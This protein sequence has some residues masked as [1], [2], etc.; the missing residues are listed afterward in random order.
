MAKEAFDRWNT[1]EYRGIFHRSP[2]VLFATNHNARQYVD[3]CTQCLD[4]QSLPWKRLK[5][6]EETRQVFPT[7]TG[8]CFS[9]DSSEYYSYANLSAGWADARRAI[10]ALGLQC[11]QRGVSFSCGPQ[12]A[13]SSL[14]TTDGGKKITAVETTGGKVVHGDL[15][16]LAT[17]AW[18]SGI[19][20][21]Y[22]SVIST[23]QVLGFVKLTDQEVDK[24]KDLPICINLSSG[25][26][27]FPP[28]PE[29]KY[30]KIAVH[31]WGYTN[32]DDRAKKS[33]QLS[34]GAVIP[35]A[36]D[37]DEAVQASKYSQPPRRDPGDR[38]NFAPLDGIHRLRQGLSA[39]VPEL[40]TREFERTAVCWYTDTPTGDFIMDYHPDHSNLFLATGGSGQ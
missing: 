16:I 30:L 18:T 27:S 12:W 1:P 28:H 38:P 33:N 9:S 24:Y 34:N 14:R 20:P 11:K 8:D 36:E 7:V 22:N 29:S 39:V 26:F 37:E 17:G 6:P 5:S 32:T 23:G 13:V 25:W 19:V 21:M 3:K 4:Q 31:G 15:F 10:V 2:F 35:A 40:A